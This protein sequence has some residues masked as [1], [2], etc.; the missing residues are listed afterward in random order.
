MKQF[1]ILDTLEQRNECEAACLDRYL[2]NGYSAERWSE[3]QTR[4]TD[5]KCIIPVCPFYDN[6]AGYTI[7]PLSYDWWAQEDV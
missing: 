5:V 2:A 1:Y 3:V 4:I 7:E 6:A